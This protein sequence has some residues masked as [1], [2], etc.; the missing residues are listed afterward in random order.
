MVNVCAMACCSFAQ[1]LNTVIN[2]VSRSSG[3]PS[4]GVR[5][6]EVDILG[7]SFPGQIA[8]RK[9][10]R[11]LLP[12]RKTIPAEILRLFCGLG[13]PR[14]PISPVATFRAISLKRVT[15]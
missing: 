14:N 5:P 6:Q 2:W 10:H 8:A 3:R 1:I 9:H 7:E 13:L 12:K 11:L 4:L 15:T